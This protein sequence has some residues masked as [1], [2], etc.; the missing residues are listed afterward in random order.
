MQNFSSFQPFLEEIESKSWENGRP[1]QQN[2]A[3]Y[4]FFEK[5]EIIFDPQERLAR[6]G[7]ES[8]HLN[9]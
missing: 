3:R 6:T 4:K 5:G 7:K 1:G 9:L 2:E 8:G